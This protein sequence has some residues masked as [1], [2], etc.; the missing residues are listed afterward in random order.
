MIKALQF[1]RSGQQGQQPVDSQVF[2]GERRAALPLL[3]GAVCRAGLFETF[4]P[5]SQ[6]AGA[7]PHPAHNRGFVA[8]GDAAL[9]GQRQ[10]ACRVLIALAEHD[11]RASIR[12]HQRPNA[13][14]AGLLVA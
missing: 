1:R 5:G 12:L 7:L 10:V 13:E 3:R 9:H 14:R 2:E 11:D 4:A 6:V 8:F